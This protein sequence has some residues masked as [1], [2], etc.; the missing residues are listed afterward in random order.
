MPCVIAISVAGAGFERPGWRVN[1]SLSFGVRE[2]RCG[3][4]LA[5]FV[6]VGRPAERGN[7]QL[8]L[9]AGRNPG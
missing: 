1:A 9:R 2:I 6:A 3:Y 4:M 7:L 5:S 8:V